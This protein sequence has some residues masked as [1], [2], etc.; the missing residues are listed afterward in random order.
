MVVIDENKSTYVSIGTVVEFT[1]EKSWWYMGCKSCKYE[2]KKGANFYSCRMCGDGIQTFEPRYS[3][4]L[5]VDDETDIASFII[6]ETVRDAF[7][8]VTADNLRSTHL[9]RGGAKDEFPKE[10]DVF[11][12]KKFLFKVIVKLENINAFQPVSISVVKLCDEESI[13][14]AFVEKYNIDN[15]P[16]IE[17]NNESLMLTQNSNCQEISKVSETKAVDDS[18]VLLQNLRRNILPVL[19]L[20]IL[21]MITT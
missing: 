4:H 6:Y 21:S 13:I 9:L 11:I 15:V 18:S 20:M 5:K 12:G 2:L 1:P 14:H 7:V 8:G 19:A 17:N 10:L 3:L 16:L